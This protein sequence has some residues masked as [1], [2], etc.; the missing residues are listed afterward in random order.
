MAITLDEADRMIAA[1]A[2]AGRTLRVMENFVFYEPLRRLKEIV[3][4]GVIGEPVGFAMKMVGTGLGGWDVPLNTWMWQ[5][6]MARSGTG[7]LTFDD[8]WH[9]YAV[10]HWLFG[11]VRTV[12][13]WVGQTDLGGGYVMDAP[14]TIAWEHDTGLRGAFDITLAPDM[15]MKSDYYSNDERFEV[16]GKKG[17][18]RVNHCTAHGLQQPALEVY[19]DGVLTGYHALDDDWASS[20]RDSTRHAVDALW[21]G[22]T[23]N[24][25]FSAQEARE[26]LAFAL[27]A[28]ESTER[29]GPVDLRE[30]SGLGG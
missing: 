26:I 7:I 1:A 8:G 19:A 5:M 28:Y 10:A 18:V 17:F 27:S 15:V 21:S 20:F 25:L 29:G 24:L 12:L 9:K 6:D 22:D 11:P 14:A 3:A 13:A 16:T 23:D 30:F 2:E 4:S